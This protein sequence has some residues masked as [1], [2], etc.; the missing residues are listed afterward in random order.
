MINALELQIAQWEYR[1]RKKYNSKRTKQ[2]YLELTLKL[3]IKHLLEI[4]NKNA[5][6]HNNIIKNYSIK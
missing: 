5:F 6:I 4:E 1:T 3:N 2:R